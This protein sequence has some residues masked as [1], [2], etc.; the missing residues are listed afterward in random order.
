ML[1]DTGSILRFLMW[2]VLFPTFFQGSFL[3]FAW[4]ADDNFWIMLAKRFFILL[5]TLAV[6]AGCWISI[7][8]VVTLIFRH[9]RREFVTALFITWW[10]LGKSVVSFWG[11][12]FRF[13]FIVCGAIVGLVKMVILAVWA[14]VEQVFI[15]P[16]RAIRSAGQNVVNSRVPW[17]AVFLTV[18]WCLIEAL[19]FTYVTTPLVSDTLSNITGEQLSGT[20]IR[21]P[22]FIFLLFVVLG[23]YAVLSNFVNAVKSRKV[24]AIAGIA[25]VEFVVLFVE[26]VFLYR[27]FVDSLVPWFAQYSQGFELGIFWTLALACLA[28][29]GIRSISWFLFA[30]HG[31]PTILSII[32]GKGVGA[33]S[34]AEPVTNRVAAVS[35]GF[36]GK[37]KADAEWVKAKGDE[38]L[39]AFMLPPL[40]V[41]AATIN[42]CTLL[43]NG[44]HLFELPFTGMDSIMSS[45]SLL[46]RVP[47]GTGTVQES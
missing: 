12:I 40:Q 11:G 39:A 35:E 43:V 4:G 1:I 42:F 7:P 28:W 25:V 9:K 3:E 22:L 45:R 38:I 47:A 23:S 37:I 8:S 46:A 6:I 18:F 5:P 44:T 30:A 41:V 31:T 15:M 16:F 2:I 34:A 17:I 21:V 29:F 10:D 26:V 27:E 33:P 36:M 32:Q 20:F 14:V 19:I 13:V 24:G